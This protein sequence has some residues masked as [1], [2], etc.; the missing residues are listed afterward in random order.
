MNLPQYNETDKTFVYIF[1]CYQASFIKNLLI[2]S[3]LLQIFFFFCNTYNIYLC[4]GIKK[5]NLEVKIETKGTSVETQTT[6]L[7]RLGCN[8]RLP[9]GDRQVELL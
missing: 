6:V 9:V 4:I 5:K 1:K 8:P 2:K 7:T 3:S